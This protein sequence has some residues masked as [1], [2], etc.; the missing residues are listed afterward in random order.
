MEENKRGKWK[1]KNRI[2]HERDRRSAAGPGSGRFHSFYFQGPLVFSFAIH[3]T[4]RREKEKEKNERTLHPD[5]H[6]HTGTHRHATEK[7]AAGG[8]SSDKSTQKREKRERRD[9]RFQQT[10]LRKKRE[11]KKLISSS[12][13]VLGCSFAHS[14]LFFRFVFERRR[15][16]FPSPNATFRILFLFA[17]FRF[18]F[19]SF[20]CHNSDLFVAFSFLS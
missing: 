1:K 7:R 19:G 6:S 11:S 12:F 3:Q 18:F 17:F 14:T 13:F 5:T 10:S 8:P 2:G 15:S 4:R 9:K 20:H 16:I